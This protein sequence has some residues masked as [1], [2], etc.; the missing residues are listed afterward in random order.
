MIEEERK[1]REFYRQQKVR[2][3]ELRSTV[4]AMI[5]SVSQEAEA[6][7]ANMSPEEKER[8]LKEVWLCVSLTN[9]TLQQLCDKKHEET[10]INCKKRTIQKYVLRRYSTSIQHRRQH[11]IIIKCMAFCLVDINLAFYNCAKSQ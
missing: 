11:S 8:L 10:R 5:E 1:E 6:R 3:N 9:L 2:K 4:N 7:V